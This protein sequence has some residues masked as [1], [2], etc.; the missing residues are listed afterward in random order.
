M[1]FLEPKRVYNGPFDGHHDRP[2][3][4]W[5]KHPLGEV[6]DGPLHDRA[7]QGARST[8]PGDELTVLAYGTLVH[9]AQAAAEEQGIDAEIIDLRTLVPLDVDTIVE[10]VAQDRAAA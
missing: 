3:V 8:A 2:I 1:I 9:V 10:S 5:S 7:R 6:P 4:P